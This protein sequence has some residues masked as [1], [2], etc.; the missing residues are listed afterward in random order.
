MVIIVTMEIAPYV[1]S[2]SLIYGKSIKGNVYLIN[3]YF[4]S[5]PDITT[6]SRRRRN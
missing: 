6:E 1:V 3:H 4:I 5:T 2:R